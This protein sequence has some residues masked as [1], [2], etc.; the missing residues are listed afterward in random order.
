MV[1]CW[2]V[3]SVNIYVYIYVYILLFLLVLVFWVR[4]SLFCALLHRSIFVVYYCSHVM[5]CVFLLLFFF[6]FRAS[7]QFHTMS[8]QQ[9]WVQVQDGR[10]RRRHHHHH[11]HDHH[12]TPVLDRP[13][14]TTDS[15]SNNDNE[16]NTDDARISS[17]GNETD[18]GHSLLK[19]NV[20]ARFEN[21]EIRR[22][23]MEWLD[24]DD[25][26]ADDAFN[27]SNANHEGQHVLLG[28]STTTT[29]TTTTTPTTNATEDSF[30]PCL[31]AGWDV[32]QTYQVTSED[33]DDS[34]ILCCHRYRKILLT[35]I[36]LDDH[37]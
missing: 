1:V 2:Y 12:N 35:E 9:P 3:S 31:A 33:D 11:H 15:S 25:H 36:N 22:Y 32:A 17:K 20:H 21:C 5:F 7:F 34:M 19:R 23:R 29:T 37:I 18:L 8:T 16:D 13:N 30:N 14:S 24:N 26:A 28:K 10:R 27:S 4:F 6:I